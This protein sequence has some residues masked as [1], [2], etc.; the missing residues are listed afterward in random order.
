MNI[1]KNTTTKTH[2]TAKK[3]ATALLIIIQ[4][5][6]SNKNIMKEILKK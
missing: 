1:T 4:K 5:L 3:H 2:R 6:S